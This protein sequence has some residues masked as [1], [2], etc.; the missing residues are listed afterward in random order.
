MGKDVIA[1][2]ASTCM[3]I[4]TR[5]IART[6]TGI[7]DKKLRPFKIG[8]TPFAV[9][10]VIYQIEPATRAEI[11]RILHLDPSTLTRSLKEMLCAGWAEETKEGADG[12]SRPIV[13]T[14]AGRDLLHKAVPAWQ[15]AQDQVKVLLGKDGVIAT[16][17]VANRIMKPTAIGIVG[18]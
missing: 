16:M 1:E 14:S 7:Y 2:M 15:S 8:S 12:R 13:L 18:I 9:L 5:L 6:I 4:R 11:G 10:V 3:F 17:D